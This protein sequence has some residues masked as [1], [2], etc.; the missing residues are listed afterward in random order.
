[1][2]KEEG[3]VIIRRPI[4]EVFAYVGDLRHSPEWQAG[5][6]EVR[7][8]TEGPLGVGTRFTVVR[9]LLGRKLELSSEFVAYEPNTMVTFRF[10][11]S[12][13]GEGS[14]L[15]ESTQEGTR[16]TSRVEM[17]PRGFSRLAES[18]IA[19]SLRRQMQANLPALKGQ[20]EYPAS[21]IAS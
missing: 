9:K 3:S 21:G 7:K 10:S 8:V 13:P 4:E 1:M 20:L 11:G 15:F 16:V 6:L 5:L 12:V 2:V 18:L 14:Y 19:A 17:R